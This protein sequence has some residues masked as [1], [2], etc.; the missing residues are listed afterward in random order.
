[1]YSHDLNRL[2]VLA[3]LETAL[4][5]DPDAMLRRYWDAVRE[6]TEGSRYAFPGQAD[7]EELYLA[8]TDPAHG[9]LQWLQRHW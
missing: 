5:A 9:V 1:M 6:W 2:L 8:V 3:Q 7:A 4:V